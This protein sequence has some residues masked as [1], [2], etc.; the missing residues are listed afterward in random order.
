MLD[1]LR[2]PTVRTAFVLTHLPAL[3][4]VAGFPAVPPGWVTGF[5]HGS[6]PTFDIAADLRN[7]TAAAVSLHVGIP[8]LVAAAAIWIRVRRERRRDVLR[9]LSRSSRTSGLCRGPIVQP[10]P[11]GQIPPHGDVSLGQVQR[12]DAAAHDAREESR[13]GA[14]TAS[15]VQ[16][17]VA[18]V[19]GGEVQELQRRGLSPR[20]EVVDR[21]EVVD[22]ERLDRSARR[23]KA[24]E[25]RS[26]EASPAVVPLDAGG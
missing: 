25:D 24:L 2:Y 13:G 17:A 22:A 19:D 15:N 6:P 11:L 9:G 1:P 21:H 7:S 20:V 16:D 5:P 23:S 18:G 3:A 26:A 4:V 8:A 14:E 10:H 12:R